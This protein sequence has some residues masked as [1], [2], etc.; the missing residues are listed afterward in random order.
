MLL[1]LFFFIFFEKSPNYTINTPNLAKHPVCSIFRMSKCAAQVCFPQ[2]QETQSVAGTL[3]AN[4]S[5]EHPTRR[6]ILEVSALDHCNVLIVRRRNTLQTDCFCDL[7]AVTATAL[8]SGLARCLIPSL[9]LFRLHIF[10]LHR[11]QILSGR[12]FRVSHHGGEK[13]LEK[14]FRDERKPSTSSS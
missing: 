13:K 1:C 8:P 3:T 6:S 11:S 12:R 5:A 4:C 2:K 7:R 9:S 14:M 10:Q